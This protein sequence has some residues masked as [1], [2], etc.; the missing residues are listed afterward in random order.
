MKVLLD[1]HILLWTLFDNKKLSSSAAEII[2]NYDN[3]IFYSIASLWEIQIKH[4]KHPDLMPYSAKEIYE[5]LSTD[6]DIQMVNIETK[7][8]VQ[9][10]NIMKEEIHND[11]F[12]HIILSTAKCDEYKLITH[13]KEM[14]KYKGIDALVV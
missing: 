10:G 3:D 1:T 6:S 8:L 9:L 4:T 14:T 2:E 11:P 5:V 7:H 12:D 13:D